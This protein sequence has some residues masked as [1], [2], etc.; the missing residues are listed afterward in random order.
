MMRKDELEN[1]LFW[2]HTLY[3]PHEGTP[4]IAQ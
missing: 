2:A 1:S 4:L 3:Q